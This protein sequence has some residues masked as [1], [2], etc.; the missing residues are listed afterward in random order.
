ML[1]I[2]QIDPQ[3]LMQV[4][5]F[6]ILPY[7]LFANCP[8]WV[9]PLFTSAL[10]LFDRETHPLYEYSQVD[11]FLAVRDGQDVGRI[12]VYAPAY[13][14]VTEANFYLFDTVDDLEI[15]TALFEQAFEWARQ[16]GLKKI[17]GPKGFTLLDGNGILIEGF[18]YPP[19]IETMTYNYEYYIPLI[20]ANGFEKEG[21]HSSYTTSTQG[22]MPPRLHQ[23]ADWIVEKESLHIKR[24]ST[25]EALLPWGPHFLETFKKAF[26]YPLMV[27]R[28]DAFMMDYLKNRTNP[29]LMKAIMHEEEMVGVMLVFPNISA[30]LQ[31]TK[32]HMNQAQLRQA[33]EESKRMIILGLGI[34]PEFQLQGVNAVFFSEIEK[35]IREADIQQLDMLWLFEGTH[36]MIND[37]HGLGLQSTH[38]HRLY[39]RDL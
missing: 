23:M 25:L 32:G 22:E 11:F 27:T 35:T 5:R 14:G 31:H 10:Q 26:N 17:I 38:T 33:I 20:E 2:E 6:V 28:Q 36:R 1:K 34:L 30:A 24:F 8:Q 3:S 18:D 7:H 13:E 19:L 16:R 12:A 15:A 39:M 21:D 9:P 4:Y 29:R 37:L